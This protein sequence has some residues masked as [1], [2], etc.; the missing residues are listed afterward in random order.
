[1]SF[2]K[3]SSLRRLRSNNADANLIC[4]I[5]AD[6]NAY[7]EGEVAKLT[8]KAKDGVEKLKIANKEISLKDGS[9][10]YTIESFDDKEVIEAIV[11]TKSGNQSCDIV[12]SKDFSPSC[13]LASDKN[14]Y[15][16]G[17][18]ALLSLSAS[19]QV[20]KVTINSSVVSL[21][22]GKA[23]LNLGVLNEN[24]SVQAT[25]EGKLGSASCELEINVISP[26][27]VVRPDLALCHNRRGMGKK[28]LVVNP[29]MGESLPDSLTK[30]FQDI[31]SATGIQSTIISNDSPLLMVQAEL[32]ANRYD[33]IWFFASCQQ[34]VYDDVISSIKKQVDNGAGLVLLG[35]NDPCNS[36]INS[37][38]SIIH[39]SWDMTLS[40]NY[41]GQK[42][43]GM[44]GFPSEGAGKLFFHPTTSGLFQSV[45][46]GMTVAEI[47]GSK[48]SS[49]S[50]TEVLRNTRGNI[51]VGAVEEMGSNNK[52]QRTLIHGAFTSMYS[53]GS[54]TQ[55]W[56]W[57][58]PSSP[59]TPQFFSNIAC[60]SV[61]L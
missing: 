40:G 27:T 12:L 56:S 47:N 31:D 9:A 45:S 25:V 54:E 6:K 21:K 39:P 11:E 60:W 51:S 50:F 1:M 24:K 55:T 49:P 57:N 46:E 32:A 17:A 7:R 28:I 59:G 19:G 4:S 42:S 44:D 53:V 3:G 33:A 10:E 8:I 13:T 48:I 58:S 38:L 43:V 14:I 26:S 36:Q 30:A 22:D 29:Y 15:M 34:T 35:D 2:K 16:T 20:D 5:S 41:A 52:I 37:A 23:S 61:G 18:S